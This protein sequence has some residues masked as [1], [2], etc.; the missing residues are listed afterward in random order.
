MR[1][2]KKKSCCCVVG[3]SFQFPFV[4][5]AFL[6]EFRQIS[7]LKITLLIFFLSLSLSLRVCVCVPP[8]DADATAAAAAACLVA[9]GK[10]ST[11]RARWR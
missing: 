2:L 3:F 10:S 1:G 5:N 8:T 7:R 9:S 11:L 4:P 6:I